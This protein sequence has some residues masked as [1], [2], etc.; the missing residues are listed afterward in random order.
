[1]KGWSGL[2]HCFKDLQLGEPQ[3][4]FLA[5]TLEFLLQAAKLWPT[6]ICQTLQTI[7]A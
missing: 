1:M 7:K 5:R 2:Q 3:A 6:A 4:M